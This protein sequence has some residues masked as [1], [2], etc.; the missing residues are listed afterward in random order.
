MSVYVDWAPPDWHGKTAIDDYDV[1]YRTFTGTAN[2]GQAP[3][4]PV[5]HPHDGIVTATTITMEHNTHYQAQCDADANLDSDDTDTTPPRLALTSN[6]GGRE[7]TVTGLAVATDYT[8]R[9]RALNWDG[10]QDSAVRY[11]AW[12]A[13]ASFPSGAGCRRSRQLHG[14]H[15]QQGSALHLGGAH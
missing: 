9:V 8:A 6:V 1:E 4:S 3:A 13:N 7:L 5:S 10:Q 11:G 12:S 15:S 14:D 2:C